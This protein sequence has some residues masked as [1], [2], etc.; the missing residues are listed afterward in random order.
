MGKQARLWNR[1]GY[2]YFR[3]V[4]PAK[5]LQVFDCNELTYSLRTNDQHE[6]RYRCLKMLQIAQFLFMNLNVGTQL[7]SAQVRAICKTSA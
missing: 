7:E 5:L 1:N 6:V 3:I 4:I 2:F